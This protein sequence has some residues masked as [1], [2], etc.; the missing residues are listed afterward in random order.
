MKNF[1]A[2]IFKDKHKL[3]R[4]LKLAKTNKYS[5]PH[6]AKIFLCERK[7]IL[8]ILN[9]CKIKLKNLGKFKKKY[10]C[11]DNFFK[12]LIPSSTYWLGF[13]TA[14]GCLYCGKNKSKKFQIAL[15]ESDVGH[16]R[17]FKKALNSNVKIYFIKS[18]RSAG[19]SLSSSVIFDSLVSLGVLPN[20]SFSMGTVSVPNNLMSHF[21]R[22]VF[23]GDGSLSG[24]RI[25]HL[26]IAI[27]GHTPL[28]RQIQN[29]FIK[30]CGVKKVNLY[31]ASYANGCTISR[32]QY[33]GSQIFRILG[34][35]Y[36]NSTEETRLKRKYEK[37]LMFK[38]KFP[39][40]FRESMEQYKNPAKL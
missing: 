2:K 29:I 9:L 27:V 12:T 24:E 19:F 5:A 21:I 17:Y 34:F 26:Q 16:L 25:T 4:L 8:G 37:Y 31:P 14:D 18:N 3:N 1:G 10:F 38:N 32:L 7:T 13:V 15:K 22:G 23:D 39:L 20:K 6:L 33:T 28:L 36:K 30:K 11:N 40:S 35:L